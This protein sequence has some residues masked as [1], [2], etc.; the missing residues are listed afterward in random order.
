MAGVDS[1]W[2]NELSDSI[3]K[4]LAQWPIERTGSIHKM[5]RNDSTNWF[6]RNR[7]IGVFVLRN[8]VHSGTHKNE[9][10]SRNNVEKFPRLLSLPFSKKNHLST[11]I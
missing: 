2:P 10:R 7:S 6:T 8:I 9:A 5:L 3:D 4:C 1:Q 11:Q